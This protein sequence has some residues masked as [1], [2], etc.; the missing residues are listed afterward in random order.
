MADH[1]LQAQKSQTGETRP[2]RTRG[3]VFFSPRVDIFEND[4]ELIVYADMPG[5][6]P[7]NVDL[8]YER[9]ELVLHGHY[10]A[11]Q[12]Q[13]NPLS[14]EYEEG[15][16]YR[17][18]QIHESIDSSKIEASCKNG[19]LLIRLPKAEAARPRQITVKG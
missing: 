4:K 8:H 19:V 13:T 15:D 18:F 6:R 14:R 7:E 11:P 16:Y 3:G 9:G 1:S 5:V 17:V 2:E 10:Q 12:R